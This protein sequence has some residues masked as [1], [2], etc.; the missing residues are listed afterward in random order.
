[1]RLI[2]PR[3]SMSLSIASLQNIQLQGAWEHTEM[4]TRRSLFPNDCKRQF[5]SKEGS[6]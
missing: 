1:M 3:G 2:L 6:P 4:R 5:L